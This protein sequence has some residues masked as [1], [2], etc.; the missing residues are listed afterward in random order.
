[1]VLTPFEAGGF[2]PVIFCKKAYYPIE[3]RSRF[4]IIARLPREK[5]LPL[6]AGILDKASRVRDRVHATV[7]LDIV[8][9]D[10]DLADMLR[11]V[12]RFSQADQHVHLT[13]KAFG[14]GC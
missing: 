4:H 3:S 1:M 6:W 5:Q 13:H 7:I 12:R 14:I 10:A 2:P 8:K 9:A 11:T